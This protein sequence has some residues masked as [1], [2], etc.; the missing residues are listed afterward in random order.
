MAPF[1]NVPNNVPS[2]LGVPGG[3]P[4]SIQ[5]A[6]AYLTQ[7]VTG[8]NNWIVQDANAVNWLLASATRWGV[9]IL[10]YGADPTGAADSA[11]AITAA[12]T[13]ALATGSNLFIPAGHYKILSAITGTMS[14]SQ[15][16]ITIQGAGPDVSVLYWPNAVGSAF[17]VIFT[18][19]EN[20]IHVRDLTFSTGTTN[21]DTA[22]QI[23]QIANPPFGTA[24]G[25]Q[26]CT[27]SNLFFRAEEGILAAGWQVVTH[28][29]KVGIALSGV[30]Y[31]VFNNVNISGP[32]TTGVGS[33]FGSS[34]AGIGVALNTANPLVIP[35]VFNFTDCTFQWL[36][37]G[38]EVSGLI[39]G[40][41]VSQCNFTGSAAG[42]LTLTAAGMDQLTVLGSQFNCINGLQLSAAIP[43]F[44][45]IGNLF[46][47]NNAFGCEGI[48]AGPAIGY[49]TVIVG[50]QF[51]SNGF[52]PPTSASSSYGVVLNN[53]SGTNDIVP[54]VISGNIFWNMGTAIVLGTNTA[55][56]KVNNNIYA[57]NNTTISNLGTGNSIGVA[58]P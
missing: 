5:A 24:A 10:D 35:V 14:G 53:G 18:S 7:I 50:N 38:I 27:F 42:I 39:Q 51:Q 48:N 57:G 33:A 17:Q 32:T 23:E 40:I 26:Q 44:S 29:W 12:L 30:G 22:L 56:A 41:T 46:I 55:G 20:T 54:A 6:A 28:N 3:A 16:A 15:Q 34:T 13:A 8:L 37:V 36:N 47:Q 43:A 25:V 58:S 49:G 31:V 4:S 9:N 45:V 19:L 21:A 52:V 11:P 2:A 1:N